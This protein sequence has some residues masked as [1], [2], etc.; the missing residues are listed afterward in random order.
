[1]VKEFHRFEKNIYFNAH[2][3]KRLANLRL[4]LK[5]CNDIYD[6]CLKMILYSICLMEILKIKSLE[7]NIF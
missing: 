3:S 6:L 1:M 5:E 2:L 4:L 7:K